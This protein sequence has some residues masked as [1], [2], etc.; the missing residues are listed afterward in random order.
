MLWKRFQH[1]Y[2]CSF[3]GHVFIYED[4]LLQLTCHTADTCSD[5]NREMWHPGSISHLPCSGIP[6]Q[7]CGPSSEAVS[8]TRTARSP[9]R[10]HR[11][12]VITWTPC[13]I[14]PTLAKQ[15]I[16][17][18]A[19]ISCLCWPRVARHPSEVTPAVFHKVNLP[20]ETWY[21]QTR[22]IET[23]GSM[24]FIEFFTSR[25][26][27]WRSLFRPPCSSDVFQ[28]ELLLWLQ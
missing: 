15:T 17:A 20:L 3:V 23:D 1:W 5:I 13:C 2:L 19:S 16:R 11:G 4:S 14:V 28:V 8:H 24:T 26:W 9:E 10:L 27:S 22:L 6:C 12:K 25:F 7:P 21:L 18:P